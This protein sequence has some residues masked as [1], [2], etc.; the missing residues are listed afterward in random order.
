[1]VDWMSQYWDLRGEIVE[2]IGVPEPVFLATFPCGLRA[3]YAAGLNTILYEAG[4]LD[5]PVPPPVPLPNPA[6]EPDPVAALWLT[7]AVDAAR[8]GHETETMT[9]A[10]LARRAGAALSSVGPLLAHVVRIDATIEKLPA[11]R[12]AQFHLAAADVHL[13][14]GALPEANGHFRAALDAEPQS[15]QA[16][17]GLARTRGQA[18]HPG[19]IDALRAELA[20]VGDNSSSWDRADAQLRQR[21]LHETRAALAGANA[22]IAAFRR[23]RVLRW[24]QPLRRVYAGR[25]TR[26]DE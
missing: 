7:K 6:D 23:S 2:A 24:T 4:L 1:M 25:R 8:R 9:F 11:A 17:T 13:A 20:V 12:Q 3:H 18:A 22:E 26:R 21:Q 5:Q 19:E 16:S 10:R 14:R 15:L